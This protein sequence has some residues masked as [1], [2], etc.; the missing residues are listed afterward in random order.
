MFI[1]LF[2]LLFPFLL[3]A[4]NQIACLQKV[5]SSFTIAP[6]SVTHYSLSLYWKIPPS[7]Y[8]LL[9][10]VLS[11][12]I[13]SHWI[14]SQPGLILCDNSDQHKKATPNLTTPATHCVIHGRHTHP[15]LTT[16]LQLT[17]LLPPSTHTLGPGLVQVD[18]IR[19]SNP[20]QPCSRFLYLCASEAFGTQ[21]FVP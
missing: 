17:Y 21:S 3:Q 16:R 10:G 9:A 6:Q 18:S 12:Y 13:I 4:F 14:A 19:C 2:F 11:S 20:R 1:C 5:N 7:H 15:I 8:R